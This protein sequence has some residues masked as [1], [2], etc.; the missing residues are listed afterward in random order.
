[1]FER[2]LARFCSPIHP[3]RVAASGYKRT[4]YPEDNRRLTF[5]RVPL[6]IGDETR[7]R[8]EA[9]RET[10]GI[11]RSAR[12]TWDEG[13]PGGAGGYSVK[14]SAPSETEVTAYWS[15]RHPVGSVD[16]HTAGQSRPAMEKLASGPFKAPRR[17]RR[18][19]R[20]S[21]NRECVPADRNFVTLKLIC[22]SNGHYRP[23][24]AGLLSRRAFYYENICIPRSLRDVYHA[25]LT[26]TVTKRTNNLRLL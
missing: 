17:V 24:Q 3:T 11:R 16:G 13:L 6:I 2:V 19:V 14:W 8:G 23:R 22:L 9:R 4:S 26:V 18:R 15:N 1:M 21:R 5:S 25:R 12:V 7:I 20:I 10:A